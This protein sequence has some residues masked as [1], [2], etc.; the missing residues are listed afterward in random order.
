MG[1]KFTHELQ[2]SDKIQSVLSSCEVRR[3][4]LKVH[5]KN[6]QNL[7]SNNLYSGCPV[8]NEAKGNDACSQQDRVLS[9][10]KTFHFLFKDMF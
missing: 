5:L 1:D 2:K 10:E 4:P 6:E 7:Q 3:F 9:G 8:Y